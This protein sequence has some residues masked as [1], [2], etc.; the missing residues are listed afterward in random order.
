MSSMYPPFSGPLQQRCVRCGTPLPPNVPMCGNCGIYNNLPQA[1]NFMGSSTGVF[2][3]APEAPTTGSVQFAGWRQPQFSSAHSAFGQT[4]PSRPLSPFN[5]NVTGQPASI[6]RYTN[7]QA[8]LYNGSSSGVSN[9]FQPGSFPGFAPNKFSEP[10]PGGRRLRIALLILSGLL[11]LVAI[12]SSLVGLLNGKNRIQSTATATPILKIVTPN[13]TPLFRDSFANN[14]TRWVLSNSPGK[15][16]VSV[17]GGSMVLEDDSHTL[18]PEILPGKSFADF[19]L[20]VDATLTKGDNNNG[21][22][23][24]IRGASSLDSDIGLYYR[25]ELYGDG[26]FAIFKGST[27]ANG[28]TQSS[29]VVK[30]T[31]NAAIQKEGQVNH[32]TVI[33]KGGSMTL[34]VNGTTMYTLSDS[35]YKGGLVALFVSNV[36]NAAPDAQV[37]FANLAIFPVS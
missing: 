26:T 32:I 30:D 16:S 31:L 3:P 22:G 8:D 1:N 20:D 19:R 36:Q 15:Y 23:V 24:Y 21:Y 27:D 7:T 12:G 37:K 35:S 13:V 2:T 17:G 14:N 10:Q 28:N 4:N 33:A 11:V 34:M 25:F 9:T 5:N 18:L 29:Q 6:N